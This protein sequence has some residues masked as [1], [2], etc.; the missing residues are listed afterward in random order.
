MEI[1]AG[2]VRREA[3]RKWMI[4]G[5]LA[6]HE[7]QLAQIIKTHMTRWDP[8]RIFCVAHGFDLASCQ[9][10]DEKQTLVVDAAN[11]EPVLEQIDGVH[12]TG[13]SQRHVKQSLHLMRAGLKDLLV[14]KKT[15]NR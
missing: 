9:N 13:G 8:T 4:A 12:R 5:A 1:N 2:H 10:R 3:A 6:T 11:A 14:R 15:K 7:V